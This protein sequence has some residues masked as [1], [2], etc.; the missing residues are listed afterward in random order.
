MKV[1]L[2]EGIE[3]KLLKN[4]TEYEVSDENS[5][6]YIINLT[7]GT[8]CHVDRYDVDVVHEVSTQKETIKSGT[9]YI[10]PMDLYDGHIKKG[11]IVYYVDESCGECCANGDESDT[12]YLPPEWVNTWEKVEED[13]FV[14]GKNIIFKDGGALING[15]LF[16]KDEIRAMVGLTPET[17]NKIIERLS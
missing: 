12:H 17:I 7:G 13:I 14:N 16:L 2:K 4:N 11:D 5:Y 10:C 8:A 1:R 6:C 15:M 9:Q 3:Y